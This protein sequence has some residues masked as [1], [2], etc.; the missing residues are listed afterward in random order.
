[1]IEELLTDKV[2]FI[3]NSQ[4]QLLP[5]IQKTLNFYQMQKE[6]LRIIPVFRIAKPI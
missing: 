5:K 2:R 3:W 6:S 1:M 4:Q